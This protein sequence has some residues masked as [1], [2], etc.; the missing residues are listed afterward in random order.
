V[1]FS[2]EGLLQ[3]L[4]LAQPQDLEPGALSPGA[5][6]TIGGPFEGISQAEGVDRA[7]ETMGRAFDALGEAFDAIGEAFET[8]G[9]AFD[10]LGEAFDTLGEAFD[11][12][13]EA[14]DAL[15]K[16][17]DAIGEAFDFV[18]RAEPGLL[19][20]FLV[21]PRASPGRRT[22][23][24]PGPVGKLNRA[25]GSLDHARSTARHF[26]RVTSNQGRALRALELSA[27][28]AARPPPRSR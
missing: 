20:P 2:F 19:W 6:E 18:R 24:Q 15:G 17:F 10:A 22:D 8:M 5:L 1:L 13:G 3:G 9:R 7:F 14:F 4:E 27:R 28:R 21:G 23:P 12:L 16:P 25:G 11:A 26:G